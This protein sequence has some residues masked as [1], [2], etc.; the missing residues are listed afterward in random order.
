MKTLQRMPRPPRGEAPAPDG[1]DGNPRNDE[2]PLVPSIG[3][4]PSRWAPAL[5][6]FDPFAGE[7]LLRILDPISPD[8]RRRGRH[9]AIPAFRILI[10]D[11]LMFVPVILLSLLPDPF[12]GGGFGAKG[13]MYNDIAYFSHISLMIVWSLLIPLGRRMIGDLVLHLEETGTLG[14]DL[15]CSLSAR[16]SS[17]SL[18]FLERVTRLT[19]RR[20]VAW[21][22]FFLIFNIITLR[23]FLS[24][25]I[26]NWYTSSAD[27]DTAFYSL[28]VGPEQPNVAGIA[29]FCIYSV[30]SGYVV[31]LAV[32]L[33]VV[34]AILCKAIAEHASLHIVPIHPDKTGGLLPI[35]KTALTFSL[36]TFSA[37]LW[38]TVQTL[39]YTWIARISL[40][41]MF[42]ILWPIYLVLAPM[43]FFLPLWPL[44]AV[45]ARAKREYL[46]SGGKAFSEMD[47]F[48][49]GH[50]AHG[51][52][53]ACDFEQ[54]LALAE[55]NDT[56]AG[57]VVWP[58]DKHTFL[59][60]GGMLV[61]PVVPLLLERLP[62]IVTGLRGYLFS[63]P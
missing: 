50:L 6:R 18:S 13:G 4:R 9:G 16:C 25:G 28:H 53:Q 49:H 2:R 8:S 39:Q 23:G 47:Q 63:A 46:V 36:F 27:V 17:V 33:F 29:H 62:S 1:R 35:G 5:D 51:D 20:V 7:P 32:R 10:I 11:S 45:M 31:L 42:L 56:A 22:F 34:F 19:P 55:L 61:S 40:P 43:L 52:F 26:A 14:E 54:H 37:G 24:D 48:H 15:D 41:S 12:W 60:F 3:D 59:R 58:F 38:L 30:F 21:A 57:M 44:W